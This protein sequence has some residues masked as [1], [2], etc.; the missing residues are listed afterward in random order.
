MKSAVRAFSII[1]LSLCVSIPSA[2]AG[3]V[4]SDLVAHWPLDGNA[5]DVVGG[6]DGEEIGDPSYVDG[7][8]GQAIELDGATQKVS[9]ADFE[10]ITD[11][12][13]FVAWLNGWK[14]EDWAGIVGSRLPLATEMIFGDNNTLHYVWNNNTMWDWAGGPVIPQDEWAMAALAIGPDRATGYIYSDADGLDASAN[15]AA[16]VEQTVGQIEIGWVDCCGG[17]RFFKGILDE[18]MIYHRELS[19]EDVLQLATQGLAVEPAGKLAI[20]WGTLK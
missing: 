1:A 10:L 15:E 18:V 2:Y 9:V 8:I 14:A 5:L 19:E 12:I 7:R 3:D 17:T 4:T 20:T 6:W 11:T 16:H 13:T